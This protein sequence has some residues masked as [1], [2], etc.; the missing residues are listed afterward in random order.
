[1][2]IASAY[3]KTEAKGAALARRFGLTVTKVG[4]GFEA[5]DRHGRRLVLRKD[6]RICGWRWMK[7]KP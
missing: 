7:G 1:M 2:H 6:T 4:Q 5:R 3:A